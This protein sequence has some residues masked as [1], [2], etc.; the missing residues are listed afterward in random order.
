[1]TEIAG[2]GRGMDEDS[3]EKV[4][5]ID[6]LR[7]LRNDFGLQL[8]IIRYMVF[9]AITI[10][11]LG[12]V[13]LSLLAWRSSASLGDRTAEIGAIFAGMTLLLTMFAA[14]VAYIAFSVSFGFP[15]LKIKIRFGSSLPGRLEVAAEPKD[16]RLEAG[17]PMQTEVAIRLHNKGRFPAKE[18]AV[19]V[20]LVGMEFVPDASALKAGGWGINERSET[21]V[22]AVQW[23]GGTAYSV[24]PGFVRE[25]PTLNLSG[26]RTTP[27]G[28]TWIWLKQYSRRKYHQAIRW[29]KRNP[30]TESPAGLIVV[31][32]RDA[33]SRQATWGRVHFMEHGN[34]TQAKQ[35]DT[36]PQH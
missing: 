23:D 29:S 25:I 35:P 26:L 5:I 3:Q 19:I 7:S 20:Q 22:T 15:D 2:G 4:G 9:A 27:D 33:A 12:T 31:S 16:G 8:L 24:P 30:V 13:A 28:I 17:N 11:L 32:I 21:G 34:L 1:M 6:R 14:L 36:T 18:L 10:I